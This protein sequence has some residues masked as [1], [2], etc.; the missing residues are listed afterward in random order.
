MRLLSYPRLSAL[1]VVMTMFAVT[2]HAQQSNAP[3]TQG[4]RGTAPATRAA[5]TPGMTNADIVNLVAAGLSEQ[6]I[7]TAIREAKAR[8]FDVTANGL[9]ALKKGGVSDS[10]IAVM[11]NPEAPPT[12]AQAPA[13][14]TPPSTPAGAQQLSV[15]LAAPSTTTAEGTQAGIYLEH[16]GELVPLEPSTFS[17][18]RTGGL[19][20]SAITAG[21]AK[22]SWKVVVRTPRAQLRVPSNP[23]FYFYFEQTGSGLSNTATP[24]AGLPG[25]VGV[26]SPNEFVLAQMTVTSRERELI[27]SESWAFG[28]TS[29]TRSQDTIEMK[30][31]RIRPGVYRVTPAS[32]L[33]PGEYCFYYAGSTAQTAGAASGGGKLFDFGF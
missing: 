24:F 32:A 12:T 1:L 21:L 26:T 17:G 33:E 15:S 11:L 3:A 31:E 6:I 13:P 10:I 16:D 9:I 29:G 8:N 14:A 2:T 27:V 4:R 19:F 7:I 22:S 5:A 28:A 20:R 25:A 18:A 23:V 30:V